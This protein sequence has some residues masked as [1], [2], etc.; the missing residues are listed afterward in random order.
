MITDRV[1]AIILS[2]GKVLLIHR[3]KKGEQYYVFPGGGIEDVETHETA[4]KREVL[5][6]LG[7]NVSVGNIFTDYQNEA[8]YFCTIVGGKLGTGDGPEFQIG[9]IDKGVYT[10]QWINYINFVQ[11]T[12][13]PEPI[14]IKLYEEVMTK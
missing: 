6:E 5:E 1:R 10:P 7:L 3:Q 2:D 14:K 4:L 9:S 12:V 13:F 11:L 8:F